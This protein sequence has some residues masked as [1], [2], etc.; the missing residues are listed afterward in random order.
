MH[1]WE[2]RQ[3]CG[4]AGGGGALRRAALGVGRRA[5]GRVSGKAAVGIGGGEGVVNVAGGGERLRRGGCWGG[6]FVCE[7]IMRIYFLY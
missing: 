2:G 5:R 4:G 1:L 3:W 6:V 7:K